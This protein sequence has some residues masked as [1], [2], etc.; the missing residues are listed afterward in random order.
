MSNVKKYR[1]QVRRQLRCFGKKKRTLLQKLDG[2]LALI[3]TDDEM[4]TWD[5]LIQALGS[6]EEM[7]LSLSSE[8]TDKDRKK[9]RRILFSLRFVCIALIA[10]LVIFAY[11]HIK[12]ALA[13]PFVFEDTIIIYEAPPSS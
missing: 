10:A 11:L 9:Y 5:D 1:R 13:M 7:A 4:P 6:P 2:S 8:L 3:E 12:I